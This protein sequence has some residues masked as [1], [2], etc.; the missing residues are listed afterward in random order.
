MQSLLSKELLTTGVFLSA[1]TYVGYQLKSVPTYIWGFLERKFLYTTCIRK[2]DIY[3]YQMLDLY[4]KKNYSGQYRNTFSYVFDREAEEDTQNHD[5]K[6]RQREDLFIL[7]I[8]GR[9]VVVKKTLER[10]AATQVH[11]KAST[12][13]EEYHISGFFA[14][15]QIEEFVQSIY[16]MYLHILPGRTTNHIYLST[17]YGWHSNKHK[18]INLVKPFSEIF[19]E[20][21]EELLDDLKG[22]L[23][24]KDWYQERYLPYRRGYLLQGLPGNGKSAVILA[25]A[26]ELNKKVYALTI[27]NDIS[28]GMLN[29]LIDDA[30][31]GSFI[32]FEDVDATFLKRKATGS[33]ISFSTFLNILDGPSSRENLVFFFTTNHVEKLDPAL[34]RPGRIDKIISITNPSGE[35][36]LQYLSN[37]YGEPKIGEAEELIKV[38]DKRVCSMAA[39]QEHC[40]SS[41]TFEKA[42]ET[43]IKIQKK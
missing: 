34:L 3:L 42:L 17:E 16:D 37:F 29:T 30:E 23:S 35:Q 28:E 4:L 36:I 13:I 18:D 41:P 15:K 43:I 32:I 6:T 39:I 10:M 9:R 33:R 5:L 12:Y 27:T 11:G 8:K 25:L 22:F 38:L 26:R 2:D 14:K 40:I 24:S 21:K 7:R 20:G 1:L 19:L 31:D